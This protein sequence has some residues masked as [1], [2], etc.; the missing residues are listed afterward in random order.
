MAGRKTFTAGS[1]FTA[2]DANGYFMNQVLQRFASAAAR[3]A[4]ITVPAEGMVAYLDD[5]NT[6]TNYSSTAWSTVGPI[7]GAF[8]TWTPTVAQLGSVT[9]TN[10]RSTY[11]RIGRLIVCWWELAVTGAGTASNNIT[12][13][14]PVTPATM[15]GVI[16]G[17]SIFDSS[18]ASRWK[19]HIATSSST[20]VYWSGSTINGF[21]GGSD[22][23]AALAS[24]DALDGW[25]A[26]T[27]AT[28]A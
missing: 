14:M 24:G 6:L 18:A 15:T 23:V 16:G 22:F 25:A 26:Y 12:I 3:D 17:G 4:A 28:D 7:N 11:I 13:S 21:L 2:A 9:V 27:A 10:T 1:I 20:F 5:V 8:T 19:A